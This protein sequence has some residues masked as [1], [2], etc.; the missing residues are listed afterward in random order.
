MESKFRQLA[1]RLADKHL[2]ELPVELVISRAPSHYGASLT[3]EHKLFTWNQ[4]VDQYLELDEA[5]LYQAY[6]R[7]I[8]GGEP[9]IKAIVSENAEPEIQELVYKLAEELWTKQEESNG[10]ILALHTPS[11]GVF[12]VGMGNG[13]RDK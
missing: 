12:K 13:G 3:D 1:Y 2:N 9:I 6:L 8:K 11:V 10:T 5:Q 4:L 7:H